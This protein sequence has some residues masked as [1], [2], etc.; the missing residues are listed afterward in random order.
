MFPELFEN[1]KIIFIRVINE[2]LRF[3]Y[4][5][6]GLYN[7]HTVLNCVRIDNLRSAKHSSAKKACKGKNKKDFEFISQYS[8]KFILGILNSKLINW[9]FMTFMS[10]GLNF[11]PDNAKQLPLIDIRE[12]VVNQEEI[13]SLVDRIIQG[14]SVGKSTADYEKQLD[15]IIYH[16]YGLSDDEMRIIDAQD[17]MR[18]IDAQ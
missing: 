15:S 7:S 6:E 3:S 10:D 1:E 17:E 9:Y 18:I 5:C 13:I 14:K 12:A 16:I 2:C 8:M 11:Y 4:D